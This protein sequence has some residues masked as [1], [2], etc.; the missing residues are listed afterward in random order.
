MGKKYKYQNGDKI[1]HL[2][3][4]EKTDKRDKKG[5]VIWLC[6]CDCGNIVERATHYFRVTIVP[7]CGKCI[8]DNKIREQRILELRDGLQNKKQNCDCLIKDYTGKKFG[9]L[10]CLYDT[11]KQTP[12]NHHI[13]HCKCDCGNEIDVSVQHLKQKFSCGCLSVSQNEYKIAKMLQVNNIPFVAEKSFSDLYYEDSNRPPRFDF[14]VNNQ[15]IIEYDGAQHFQSVSHWIHDLRH[16]VERDCI[17]NLYCFKKNIP[18]IRIPYDAEYV[19]QDLILGTT[20]FLLT[21]ENE[22]E[23]YNQRIVR[24]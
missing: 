22:F 4:L 1:G 24:K 9:L 7:S 17:K 6:K 12:N 21:P 5:E 3:I 2:T 11:K 15:Y 16:Q 19:F 23:Y 18:I 14:Y 8:I 20:R 10:T 13:W